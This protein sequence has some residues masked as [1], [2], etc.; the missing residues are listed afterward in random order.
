MPGHPHAGL[1]PLTRLIIVLIVLSPFALAVPEWMDA[2]PEGISEWSD[3]KP[4]EV[5]L[6]P[7]REP[8]TR[9]DIDE[10]RPITGFAVNA[11]HIA[12]LNLYL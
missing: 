6:L 4:V 11:H 3:G 2:G 12:D 5:K 9:L 8:G 1:R 7:A 10:R